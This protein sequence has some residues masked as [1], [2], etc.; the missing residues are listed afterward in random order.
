MSG[1]T[2]VSTATRPRLSIMKSPVPAVVQSMPSAGL[3]LNQHAYESRTSFPYAIGLGDYRD[4]A[5]MIGRNAREVTDGQ[6]PFLTSGPLHGRGSVNVHGLVDYLRNPTRAEQIRLEGFAGPYV[7]DIVIPEV[8]VR[9]TGEVMDITKAAKV[10]DG[11]LDFAAVLKMDEAGLIELIM[12]PGKARGTW[13]TWF[14]LLSNV[15]N[16][17]SLNLRG[18]RVPDENLASL[19]LKLPELGVVLGR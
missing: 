3:F 13:P 11:I 8:L 6:I 1:I 14:P 16:F 2:A 9:M 4:A 17:H 12:D 19:R 5:A 15:R 7:P 18:V 10:G